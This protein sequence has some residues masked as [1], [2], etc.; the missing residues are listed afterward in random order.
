LNTANAGL[1][2]ELN[3]ARQTISNLQSELAATQAMAAQLE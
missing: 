3:A 1:T 2:N